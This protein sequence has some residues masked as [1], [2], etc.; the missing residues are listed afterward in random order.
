M[1][2]GK[3]YFLIQGSQIMF[4]SATDIMQQNNS[5]FIQKLYPIFLKNRGVI[6]AANVFQHTYAYNT[7]KC[8]TGFFQG[9]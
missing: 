8:H 2:P 6:I 9:R 1:P 7:V 4:L 3:I 5:L